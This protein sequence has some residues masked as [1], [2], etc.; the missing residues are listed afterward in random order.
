MIY[1]N[2][3]DSWELIYNG[4]G[5]LEPV[6]G[7]DQRGTVIDSPGLLKYFLEMIDENP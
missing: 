1:R 4:G 3:V 5:A 2:L 6:A 7:G